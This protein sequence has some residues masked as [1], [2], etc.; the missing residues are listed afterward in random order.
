MTST[1]GSES[2][3]KTNQ[4]PLVAGLTA[5]GITA[6]FVIGIGVFIGIRKKSRKD[7][8]I[9][10]VSLNETRTPGDSSGSS[11]DRSN[12]SPI[13][14]KMVGENFTK[15]M[16]QLVSTRKN[17]EIKYTDLE[18]QMPPIGS[19]AFG[20]VN[21]AIYK[22]KLVAVKSMFKRSDPIDFQREVL[23]LS[24]LHHP[25]V[26]AFIGASLEP[27]AVV[28]EF[29]DHGSLYDI[30]RKD[31]QALNWDRVIN[32]LIDC[33]KGFDYLHSH[34]PPIIHRD[35]KTQ[36][37]LIDK[38]WRAKLCDFGISRELGSELTMTKT[39]GTPRWNAPE[40]LEHNVYT[41]K[42]DVYSFGCC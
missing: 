17:W 13:T 1:S 26:V 18:I 36:N 21:K 23:V 42:V 33:A 40:V 31:P 15:N 11:S 10:L 4:T 25:S 12:K 14:K 30:I 24:Q 38:E 5:I 7:G 19:G 39:I 32:I 22:G 3:E 29:A 2:S 16:D 35:L 8:N 6:A 37:I 20:V 28:T 9:P 41:E 34:E 27:M